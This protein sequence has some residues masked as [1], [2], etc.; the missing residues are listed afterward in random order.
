MELEAEQLSSLS[1]PL[2]TVDQ[3]STS[4]SQLDGVPADLESSLR[5]AGAQLTQAAGILLRLPQEIIAQAI[6]VF[7]RFYLGSEGG[8]FRINALK[9]VSAASLY[10]TAKISFLPQST[11]SVLNVYAYLLSPMSPL[12]QPSEGTRGKEKPD[13]ESYCLS[14][15]SYQAARATLLQT[16]SIILRA[17]S[18]ITRV[19]LP[20]H[21]ALTYLQTLG[22]LPPSP[23]EKSSA[24]AARTLAHLNTALFSP[25]L[26][27]LTHQPPALAVAAIYLAAREVGVKL[28]STEWWEVF[29]VDRE[30]LGFLVVGLGSC[31]GW[32]ESEKEKW[33]KTSCPLTLGELEEDIKRRG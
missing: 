5:F 28:P 16:E 6:V 9:D 7:H 29:D 24:L 30:T 27:Y 33:T 15:G 18:F 14:E 2:A 8:S 19:T 1:N 26:L 10:M 25:Q 4:S 31:E 23:T 3:L 17:I 20:H 22:V 13:A 12:R 11:R 21:V 32:I